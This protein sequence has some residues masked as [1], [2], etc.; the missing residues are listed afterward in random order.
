MIEGK[1]PSQIS[2]A[3]YFISYAMSELAT[4]K[5]GLSPVITSIHIQEKYNG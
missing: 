2:S 1:R 4:R 5:S 3:L